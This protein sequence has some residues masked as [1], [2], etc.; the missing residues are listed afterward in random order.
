LAIAKFLLAFDFKLSKM[1]IGAYAAHDFINLLSILLPFLK[2][3][4]GVIPKP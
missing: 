1:N 3:F 4:S 2:V